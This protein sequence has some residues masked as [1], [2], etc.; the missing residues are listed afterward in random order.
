MRILEA[1]QETEWWEKITFSGAHNMNFLGLSGSCLQ[2]FMFF[3]LLNETK[4]HVISLGGKNIW[5]CKD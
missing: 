2:N 1:V 5:F 3:F 4:F